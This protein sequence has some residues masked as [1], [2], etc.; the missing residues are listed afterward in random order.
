MVLIRFSLTDPPGG[1]EQVTYYIMLVSLTI[2]DD[3]YQVGKGIYLLFF[4]LRNN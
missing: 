4:K 2:K 3:Y 1:L